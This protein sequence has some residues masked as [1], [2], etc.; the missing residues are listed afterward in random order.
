M[1]IPVNSAEVVNHHVNR[2]I[3]GKYLRHCHN[4]TACGVRALI[5][6]RQNMDKREIIASRYIS[7]TKSV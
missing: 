3:G 2:K 1:P 4:C 6:Q 5:A 7:Q